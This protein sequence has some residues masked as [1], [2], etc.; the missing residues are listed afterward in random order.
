MSSRPGVQRGKDVPEPDRF[1]QILADPEMIAKLTE[2]GR[3]GRK[4][5]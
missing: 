4:Y 3:G 5:G 2:M 1:K